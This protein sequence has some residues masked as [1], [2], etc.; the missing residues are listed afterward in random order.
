MP[1]NAMQYYVILQNLKKLE[2]DLTTDN[3][4][5]ALEALAKATRA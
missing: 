3:Q 5:K 1:R 2:F 4:N